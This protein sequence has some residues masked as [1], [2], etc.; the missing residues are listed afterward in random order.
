MSNNQQNNLLT[1]HSSFIPVTFCCFPTLWTELLCLFNGATSFVC[2]SIGFIFWKRFLTKLIL[3]R[4]EKL[5]KSF[6]SLAIVRRFR[7]ISSY[8]QNLCTNK[9]SEC[10]HIRKEKLFT[11]IT[12]QIQIGLL[13]VINIVYSA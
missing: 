4:T 8:F 3:R 12:H 2:F 13:I 5:T 1:H 10:K 9:K 6:H 7:N 11:E